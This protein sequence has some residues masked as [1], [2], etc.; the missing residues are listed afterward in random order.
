MP[1]TFP[2]NHT[3]TKIPTEPKVPV[4]IA[5]DIVNRMNLIYA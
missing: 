1:C 3:L 5:C 4:A 2:A